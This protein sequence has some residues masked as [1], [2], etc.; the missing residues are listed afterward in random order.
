VDQEVQSPS[1]KVL[2]VL[3]LHHPFLQPFS[4]GQRMKESYPLFPQFPFLFHMVF[5]FLL[6]GYF[7]VLISLFQLA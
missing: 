7:M 5:P 6:V 4:F 2:F 1:S 3:K